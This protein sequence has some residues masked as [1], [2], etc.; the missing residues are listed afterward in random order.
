M[1]RPALRITLQRLLLAVL[2]LVLLPL[3]MV[4]GWFSYRA[5]QTSAEQYQTQLAREV[6][7]RIYDKVVQFFAVPQQVLSFNV[8]LFRAGLLQPQDQ[9][10]LLPFFLHQLRREPLLTFLSMGNAEGEYFSVSRPPLGKDKSLRLLDAPLSEGRVMSIYRIRDDNQR[11][12]R[13]AL[14]NRYF[15]ARTRPWFQIAADRAGMQWYLPYRYVIHDE[16]GAYEAMGMGM[17]AP[18]RNAEGHFIGV[19]N[20]DVALVQLSQLLA[21]I[22]RELGG[23][24]LLADASGALLATSISDPL[25]HLDNGKAVRIRAADSQHPV[26][27]STA[28]AMDSQNQPQGRAIRQIQG[29]PYLLDWWTYQ[30]PDGPPLRIGVALP[31]SRFNAPSENLMEHFVGLVMVSVLI[32]LLA[33]WVVSKWVARPLEA[34]GHWAQQ[35]GQG[36]WNSAQP[37]IHSPMAEVGALSHALGFMTEQMRNYTQNLESQV[38]ER[39]AALEAANRELSSQSHTDGL[40]G[41]ANRRCFDEVL[42]EEWSRAR[43]TRQPLALIMIDIDYFKRY[44]D[45][46]GHVEGDHCLRRVAQILAD[47][48][49]R[50]GD[51]VARY[52]G[53][54]FAVIAPATDLH[55]IQQLAEKLRLVIAQEA[56]PH[57]LH[58][59]GCVTAS[60]GVAIAVPD[61]SNGPEPLLQAADRALYHAKEAGRDRVGVAL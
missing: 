40:T 53:E 57:A 18:L 60:F 48:V 10:R 1:V 47:N 34:L 27:R 16:Q 44:N 4:H 39:T 23:V 17:S 56:I 2:L 51:L 36:D 26:I 25:Y 32:S 30:L 43:R 31:Q 29:E 41:L 28:Q 12:Q 59:Q 38:A 45:H 15:D 61:G 21:D 22:T 11:G 35:L 46:Y 3:L 8:Q 5:A 19:L 20:A 13:I 58:T 42:A 7:A 52:G 54:E 49:R 14:G 55:G 33:A 24:A 37:R 50:P 9:E 6:S